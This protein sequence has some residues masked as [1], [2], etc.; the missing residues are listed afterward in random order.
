MSH[1]NTRGDNL[2]AMTTAWSAMTRGFLR[3][4][5]A[6]NRAAVSAMLPSVDGENGQEGERVSPPIPSID[7]SDLD[8]QFDRTVDDPDGI[9]VGDT[10]TFEKAITDNDVRAFA[11]VSGDTNRLHL[12][13]EFAADTRFGE[14]IVHGTLASGLI[15]AALARLPG[16][17]IYLSQD[18]EFSGPVGIGDRVSARVEIV[19]NL[20]N[21]QYRL[22][23][24][25]RN[26]DAD[27]TV[28][29][30]EAVVLIDDLPDE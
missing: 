16:L 15:S 10:V 14:R 12:D 5:T 17:T 25:V 28:I 2:S 26:E 18:L 21:D 22:E 6:A 7:Y 11:A 3:T 1:Q 19:E 24:V 23:T 8:W 29:D 20:G 13:E 30:G 4:A 9:S 27:S